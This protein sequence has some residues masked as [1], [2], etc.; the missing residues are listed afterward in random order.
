MIKAVAHMRET[1]LDGVNTV[2]PYTLP[3]DI[4]DGVP[5]PVVTL[6]LR[7]AMCLRELARASPPAILAHH[8]DRVT[9]RDFAHVWKR[10]I[11]DV[12]L[13]AVGARFPVTDMFHEDVVDKGMQLVAYW[14]PRPPRFR[15]GRVVLPWVGKS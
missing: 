15:M 2:A 1:S 8:G 6:L 10:P 12:C 7:V 4:D 14:T 3:G 11:L 13:A 9:R 5:L